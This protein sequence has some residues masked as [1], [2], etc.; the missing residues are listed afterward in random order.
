MYIA[1]DSVIRLIKNCPL[2]TTYE[3]T[4]YFNSKDE[5]TAYFSG[6][7]KYTL[8]KQTYQRVNKNLMRV[9]YKA[10]DLYDCNYLMFQNTAFGNKWFYAFIKRIDYVNNI[11]S[12]IEYVIDVMQTWHFDYTLGQCFIERE[13]SRT[14]EI[15]DNTV[16]ENLELGEYVTDDFDATNRIGELAI[17]IAAT[18]DENYDDISGTRYGN[19]FSGLYYHVFDNT[20]A[21][22]QD[23]ADFISNAGGKSDGIVSVFLMP[24]SFVTNTGESPKN[25][26]ITKSKK[27]TLTRRD[28]EN[29]KNNK[30]LTYPYNFL[31][32]TNLQGNSAEFHYELF[33]GDNCGFVLIGDMTATPCVILAPTNYKGA[34]TNYDEKITLSGYPQLSYNVDTFKMWLS[35]NAL[36][37]G[38]NTLS[39][40]VN[41]STSIA[42]DM[43]GLSAMTPPL[44]AA[45]SVANSVAQVYVHSKM[46]N[47]ARGGSGSSALAAF[48]LLDFA[49][50]HKHIRPEYVS[51][52]DDYFNMFG[53]ATHRVKAP[54][55]NVRPHW[56][57]TKTAGCVAHGSVPCDD[58][59]AICRIY[60]TGI[61][62][63]KN[64]NEIGDYSLDNSIT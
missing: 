54:N 12:E 31:Y 30:L 13:H 58:M 6:L 43:T 57:Y 47:Q 11:T 49:F 64:G 55:R 10:D 34:V 16:P 56:T 52:I 33:S 2:D 37:L 18:F 53:Y 15:G 14:D 35:Q 40:A 44:S 17:V 62:F 60:N 5:Q 28:G 42:A 21:G 9:Q 32:C 61:T 63:W 29:V 22:A 7:T 24:K 27:I 46:P 26:N 38:I 25:Y 23:C 19:I 59:D 50:M 4:I 36:S 51:I 45:L 39:T 20:N 48:G 41:G 3:H 1:P 8:T